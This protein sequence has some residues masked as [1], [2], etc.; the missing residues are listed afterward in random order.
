MTKPTSVKDRAR[1]LRKA[2]ATHREIALDLFISPSTAYEWT[3]DIVLTQDKKDKIN[4]RRNVHKMSEE[5]K[6]KAG[7]RL[8][9]YW[10]KNSYTK[11]ELITRIKDFYTVNGRIPLKKEFNAWDVYVTRFGSWNAAIKE[12]GFEANPVLFSKKFLA[13]DG[14]SCDSFSE[15][16]I[17]DY[18][19]SNGILHVRNAPYPNSKF[20]ADFQAGEAFIEFFGLAGASKEYDNRISEKRKVARKHRINLIEIYPQDL[21]P[22]SKLPILVGDTGFE[23]VTS[24]V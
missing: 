11:E 12:A 19:S 9:E 10:K 17:D 6:E 15:K 20:T 14:H 8:K 7:I 4:E 18:L 22:I 16:I 24:R 1:S 2:G 3:R 21:Y 5:E 13:S 23:P